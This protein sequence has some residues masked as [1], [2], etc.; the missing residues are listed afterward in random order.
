MKAWETLRKLGDFQ[1]TSK[2][3]YCGFHNAPSTILNGRSCIYGTIETV[4]TMCLVYSMH[5]TSELRNCM[6]EVIFH[7]NTCDHYCWHQTYNF[8]IPMSYGWNRLGT[9]C[10]QFLEYFRYIIYHL[11]WY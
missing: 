8:A 9:W 5:R 4:Y 10:T 7:L 1:N 2:T 11:E 6:H 3:C